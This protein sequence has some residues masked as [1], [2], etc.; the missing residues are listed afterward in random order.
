MMPDSSH[1]LKIPSTKKKP[2]NSDSFQPREYSIKLELKP[3]P[4][5]SQNIEVNTS[6]HI[7]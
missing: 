1:Y 7:E 4:L 5:A 6:T 2:K 3:L